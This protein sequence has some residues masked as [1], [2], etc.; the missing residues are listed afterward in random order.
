MV[1]AV[2]LP[3]HFRKKLLET[4]PLLHRRGGGEALS[5]LDNVLSKVVAEDIVFSPSPRGSLKLR[6]NHK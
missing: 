2:S 4:A 1:M 6:P 3:I 5:V